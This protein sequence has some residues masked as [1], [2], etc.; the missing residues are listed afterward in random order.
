MTNPAYANVEF[1]SEVWAI[2][3]QNYG[4]VLALC[5]PHSQPE[6]RITYKELW[7]KIQQFGAGLQA[8]GLQPD[9]KVALIADNS[10]RWFVADQGILATGA[11]DAVRSAQAEK[12]ELLYIYANS[13]SQFLVVENLKTL[14]YL[15]T[16]ITGLQ[17][18]AIILLSDET[19]PESEI[20]TLNF[21]Q[22]MALGE[23]HTFQLC[24]RSPQDLLTLIYTSGTTG[25]PKGVMLSQAN[26]LF[27]IKNL[28]DVIQPNVG[29]PI[30]SILPTWHSFERAAEY[31]LL[32]QGCTQFYTSIRHIKKDL[33]T[34]KPAYMAAVPRIWESIYE[35]IQKNFRDQPEN[36]QKLVNFFLNLSTEYVMANRIANNLSLDHL[37]VSATT[38]LVNKLKA[39]ALTPLHLLGDKLVYNK[40]RE[41]TGGKMR[42]VISGG[43]SL[44]QHIDN[45]FE[46]VG[47]DI[48]V[49]YGLTETSPVTHARRPDRNLRGSSGSSLPRTETRIVDLETRQILPQGKKGIVLLRGPQIMQ[50]YYRKPEA[51]AK[52]ID[53]EGWFDSGDIGWL[54]PQGE[55]VLTGRAKDTIVLTNGENIEPQPIEDACARSSYIDQIM[56]VGQDQKSLGA[57]IVVNLLAL[58]KWVADSHLGLKLPTADTPAET[59]PQTDL[60]SKAIVNLFK[61]EI[62]RE[63]KN[64]PGYRPDDRITE[65]ALLTEPFAVENGLL[66]Q[67]LKMKRPIIT[68]KYQNVIDGIYN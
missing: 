57:L 4:D 59:L 3:A 38:R 26:M 27:Q 36:K 7:Q 67:T 1:V 64:R 10:P 34:Y 12:T 21:S 9:Q 49:G 44:A 60:Y 48:L 25:K 30:L 58:E 33:K 56:L 66:T 17:P 8:L 6:V 40:I 47:I 18:R 54:T 35:G 55:L 63:V 39:I 31:Y 29:D 68:E 62:T 52:A 61:Q 51:T 2:A 15:E 28:D 5:D 53:P 65:F 22:L 37:H 20:K 50:G 46:V 23:T 14:Q 16:E 13:E 41:A 43:G 45:F 11:V 19:P 42:Y 32:S 24:R